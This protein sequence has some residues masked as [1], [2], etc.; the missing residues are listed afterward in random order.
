MGAML[1]VLYSF[2]MVRLLIGETRNL[3][4]FTRHQFKS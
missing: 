2:P 1:N 4:D 3:G